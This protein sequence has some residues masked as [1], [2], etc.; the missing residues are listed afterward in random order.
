MLIP[1]GVSGN[2]PTRTGNAI[3]KLDPRSNS[4]LAP[5]GASNIFASSP[6]RLSAR[7]QRLSQSTTCMRPA[8]LWV[9]GGR[10]PPEAQIAGAP[11]VFAPVVSLNPPT[12]PGA[13]PRAQST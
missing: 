3:V 9:G 11:L 12:E 1:A 10:V 7:G 6:V 5:G 8:R 13:Q 4:A 2:G